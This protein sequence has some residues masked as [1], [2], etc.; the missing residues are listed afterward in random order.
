[1][2]IPVKTRKEAERLR[3]ELE[4]HNRHYYD[5]ADPV[6]SDMEYDTMM[7]RLVALEEKHPGL[8]TSDSPTLRVGGT[9]SESFES[10]EHSL[11]MLSLDNT[12]SSGE[13]LE[14]DG[15]IRRILSVESLDYSAEFKLDGVAVTLHYRD[16]RFL[17]GATRG[18]GRRGDDITGNLYTIPSIP[19]RL[20]GERMASGDVEIRGEAY[21]IFDDL[22]RI[23]RKREEAGEKIF[24]NPRNL[25]A[26][27]LKMLDP[28]IVALRPLRFMAYQI[29]EPG[30]LGIVT[31]IDVLLALAGAGF[32]VMEG[33]EL[34]GG[35]DEALERCRAMQEKRNDLPYGVDGVVLKVND[36]SLYGRLGATSKSPRWGIAYKFPAERKTTVVRTITLQVGRTGSVTPVANVEPVSLAGTVVRRATLH[37]EEEVRRLDI[38]VGD[39]VWIEKSGDIIPR[40]PGVLKEKRTG[41][42]EP[43]LFPDHCPVCDEPLLRTEDE[44]AVRC[45]NP[46]CP[47]LI[48]GSIVHYASRNAMD[49][50]GLGIK[51]VDQLVDD[52][53]LAS[54]AD[55]YHLE[56]DR[57][58]S[59]PRFG[60]KSADNLLV[61][62]DASKDR[63]LD[64]FLY[65]LG[66]HHVGRTVARAIASHFGA[67]RKIFDADEEELASIE[68]VGPVIADSVCRFFRSG[69]GAKLLGELL[70]AGVAPSAPEAAAGEG[71][72][73]S[74][75]RLVLTGSL[76]RFT[77]NEA[78]ERIERAGGK[79]VSSVSR[80]TDFVVAGESAG[81]KQKKAEE[82]G[83]RILSER[84]LIE[85][86]G[87]AE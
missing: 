27:S 66:I 11:P 80:K 50:E 83:V 87:G 86:L 9:P 82:L 36:L 29:V 34:C 79:V 4:E 76:V 59:L 75:K 8:R 52:G 74:G 12:Y 3:R 17:K 67:I 65:A 77:R 61:S 18:D 48:R 40:I 31:Q 39:T 30:K 45:V 43:F 6:V 81:S 62:L 54:I 41:A 20:E 44:V 68:A 7:S 21:I 35:I 51:V 38:R 42:E 58:A 78:I 26:G 24:A 71:S 22:Q 72:V 1:M 73:L 85:M 25:T 19:L 28:K 64:R 63:S 49:I 23:N 33:E 60:E 47:A 13:L 46:E 84:D 10:V 56:K 15:R 2:S 53:L 37:N 57:I 14:F 5:D 70:Q 69:P 32:P 16:G 55:L